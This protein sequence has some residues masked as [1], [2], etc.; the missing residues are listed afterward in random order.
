MLPDVSRS[1]KCSGGNENPMQFDI[2]PVHQIANSSTRH[3]QKQLE[4]HAMAWTVA[5]IRGRLLEKQLI[6]EDADIMELWSSIPHESH[7]RRNF[8]PYMPGSATTYP[9]VVIPF[10]FNTAAVQQYQPAR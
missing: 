8:A 6:L 10:H 4:R 5:I 3:H 1:L 2:V 7:S 9:L